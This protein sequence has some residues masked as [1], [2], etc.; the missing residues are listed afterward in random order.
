MDV[1]M[2]QKGNVLPYV[3]AMLVALMLSGQYVF[4]SYKISNESS[5]M[6]NT[7]D[8]AAY[9]VATVYA[10]NYNFVG[11]SNRA[12]V[13]NQITMAQV[14]TMVSWGRML[15]TFSTTIDDIGQFIPYV[16]TVTKYV[17]QVGKAIQSGLERIVPPVTKIIQTYIVAN[18][19][20]QRTAVPMVSLISQEILE[21]VVEKNDEDVE[22][23]LATVPLL[24][25]SVAHL[26]EFYG[27]SDCKKQADRVRNGWS[28]NGETI[29]RCRQFRNVTLASR[30][31]FTEDRTYRFRFPLMPDKIIIPG[32]PAE[33]VSGI[34]IY[35]TLTIERAGG[36]SMGGD[37]PGVQR[38]TPFT[39]WS[40]LDTISLHSSTKYYSFR[41]FKVKETRHDEKL[42]LGVGSAYVGNECSKCHHIINEG[43]NYWNKN[44]RGSACTDPDRARGYGG[45]HKSRN[46]GAFILFDVFSLNCH[47]LSNDYGRTLNGDS[48]VGLTDF[49]N[50]KTEGYVEEKD[51]VMV[52]LRKKQSDV[53]TA[54]QTVGGGSDDFILD[55]YQ[56][57]QN[58]NLHGAA[59]AAVYFRRSND[60]WMLASARRLD[61]RIEF[62]N[63]YNPFW[64]ARL[65]K[66][67]ATQRVTLEAMK[68][69]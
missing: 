27:Q 46:D 55:R 40:A 69:L 66:L 60:R 54:S 19:K 8:S 7:T 22:Y 4:N 25:G 20:L 47:K 10:Q 23:S 61:G 37:T 26:S 50:L 13:A 58:N 17:E 51:Q 24:A 42:K 39:T 30:D 5:R 67:T 59:A 28:S 35:S 33:W 31:G 15:G 52:Y 29:A 45:G 49:Y 62:G 68:E 56:G 57:A 12:L 65:S 43:T 6:Q 48:N 63:A 53:E 41:D 9:S 14:V 38:S 18:S 64:E 11:L 1:A 32:L 34:P 16:N 21:E 44:P 3:L 36:T 2:Y